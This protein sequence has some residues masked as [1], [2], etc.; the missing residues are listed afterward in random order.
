MVPTIVVHTQL[1]GLL[2]GIIGAQFEG[3]GT[4][5]PETAAR[6]CCDSRIQVVIENPDGQAVGIGFANRNPPRWLRRQIRYRDGR[7]C[8]PGCEGGR[9]MQTHHIVRWPVG[10]T[11]LDNLVMVCLFHHNLV[12]EHGWEVDLDVRTGVVTW[13]RPDG[14]AFARAGPERASPTRS[15]A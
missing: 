5:H 6:L 7:C 12:H 4:I 15:A 11:D 13:L 10:P 8:F 2:S 9:F 14:S 3:G 1:E